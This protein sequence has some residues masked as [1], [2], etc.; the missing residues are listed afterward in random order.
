MAK[1]KVTRRKTTQSHKAIKAAVLKDIEHDRLKKRDAKHRIYRMG[2]W[3]F[4]VLAIF[5]VV[6]SVWAISSIY[7]NFR[8]VTNILDQSFE[9][10]NLV[11]DITTSKI[12]SCQ[13]ELQ[14]CRNGD[15]SSEPNS[16]T[17]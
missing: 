8:V 13:N 6:F 14:E 5:S 16:S 9:R 17:T 3:L 4:F 11:L 7:S 2:F 1:K 12:S 15:V 10:T